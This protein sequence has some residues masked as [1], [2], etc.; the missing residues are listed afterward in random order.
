MYIIQ[1]VG[2]SACRPMVTVS[3]WCSG[4]SSQLDTNL[5][6]ATSAKSLPLMFVCPLILCSIVVSPSLAMY[7]RDSTIATMSGL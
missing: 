1:Y 7:R 5:L 6:V 2:R 3:L 4:M